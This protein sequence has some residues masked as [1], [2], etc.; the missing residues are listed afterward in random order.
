VVAHNQSGDTISNNIHITVQIP[1]DP[2]ESFTLST[3]A[4]FPDDDGIFSLSWTISNGADNYSIY[5]HN[6]P[7][8]V[9]DNTLTLLVDQTAVSPFSVSGLSNGEYYFVGV[10]HNQ[11]GDTISNNVHVTVSKPVEPPPPEI[12]PE[13]SGYN[14]F[15]ILGI[16]IFIAVILFKR[17]KIKY[18]IK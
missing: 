5:M 17:K 4:D 12:P 18:K 3:D 16:V 15:V 7:I 9:I 11:Y 14:T 2:P 13:I 10:A 1:E 6:N 8:T